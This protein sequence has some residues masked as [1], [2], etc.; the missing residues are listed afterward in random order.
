MNQV[1][2]GVTRFLKYI[3]SPD[4][5][6]TEEIS[7]FKKE[8]MS[9][10]LDLIPDQLLQ[11]YSNEVRQLFSDVFSS[12]AKAMK[13]AILEY[14]LRSPD[15]RKRLHI[16]MLPRPIPSSSLRIDLNGGFSTVSYSG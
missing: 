7:K 2:L 15:E 1:N 10:A 4:A 13:R 6:K 8:W 12:Y 14:I 11:R 9:R 3:E 5:I 16:L